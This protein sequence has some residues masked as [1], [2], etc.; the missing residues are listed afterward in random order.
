M[1]A[2][3]DDFRLGT[4]LVF[5][6]IDNSSPT[7]PTNQLIFVHLIMS[8]PFVL[9]KAAAHFRKGAKKLYLFVPILPSA[10]VS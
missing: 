7:R 5:D 1:V 10:S 3:M 8:G 6:F 2:A 9:D 4:N